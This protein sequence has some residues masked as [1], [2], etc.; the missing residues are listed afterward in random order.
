MKTI[1]EAISGPISGRVAHFAIFE[2]LVFVITSRILRILIEHT[3]VKNSL[4]SKL[5]NFTICT[6]R[7]LNI[8]EVIA[9]LSLSKIVKCFTLLGHFCDNS[10][11]TENSNGVYIVD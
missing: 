4:D 1:T 9:K 7:I 10:Y 8:L 5:Q 2:K 3:E 11:K 6:I